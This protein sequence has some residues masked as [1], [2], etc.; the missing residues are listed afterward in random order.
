[1]LVN[2]LVQR[3]QFFCFVFIPLSF[4]S[5]LCFVAFFFFFKFY[6]KCIYFVLVT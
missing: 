5:T 1:M 6:F 4:G 2:L 3:T